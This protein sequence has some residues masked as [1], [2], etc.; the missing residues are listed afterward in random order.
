[1]RAFHLLSV[2]WFGCPLR[3]G[4]IPS[5]WGAGLLLLCAASTVWAADSASTLEQIRLR[6]G[7]WIGPS[8]VR[9]TLEF[10]APSAAIGTRLD[11]VPAI[12]FG[13]DFWPREDL[14]LYAAGRVGLGIDLGVPDTA[15]TIAYNMHQVEAGLRYRWFANARPSAF[16]VVL[17]VGLRGIIQTVQVQRPS[18]LVDRTAV[19]PEARLGF[20][21]PAGRRLWIRLEGRAGVPFFVREGP[22]DSGDPASFVTY[23][24][25]GDIVVNLA[26]RWALQLGADF[27]QIAIDYTGEGTRT[28]GVVD[29]TTTDQLLTFD[30]GARLR[31]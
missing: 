19:G 6:Q 9:G 3:R 27:A 29:A 30:L 25:R 22:T 11:A 14:G 2:L 20:A 23:G 18:F 7:V 26:S 16:A 10:R 12:G 8:V 31:F 24:A 17:G 1:M 28:G 5:G 4:R 21:L 15:G 13:G